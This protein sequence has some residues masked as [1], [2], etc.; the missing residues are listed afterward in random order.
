MHH[1]AELPLALLCGD[2]AQNTREGR[3]SAWITF[4][5]TKTA[6]QGGFADISYVDHPSIQLYTSQ[7]GRST[8][9]LAFFSML[10]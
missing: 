3:K 6:S 4:W 9:I 2:L 8:D 10:V 7:S 5:M 1:I